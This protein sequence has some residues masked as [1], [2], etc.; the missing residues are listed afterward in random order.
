MPSIQPTQRIDALAQRILYLLEVEQPQNAVQLA[1]RLKVRTETVRD[2]LRLLIGRGR[3]ERRREG[4]ANGTNRYY[5]Y[6][7]RSSSNEKE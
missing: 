5:L 4:R 3:V 1:A 2:R 6:T 7:L